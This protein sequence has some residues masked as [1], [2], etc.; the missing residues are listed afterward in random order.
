MLRKILYRAISIGELKDWKKSNTF[1]CGKNTLEGK[2]FF[3]S[4]EAVENFAYLANKRKFEPP[5]AYI[6]EI[7]IDKEC[8]EKIEYAIQELDRYHAITIY[9]TDLAQFNKCKKEIQQYD[10]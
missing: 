8:L 6:F 2:Q 4:M 10:L 1:R 7:T 5:Y 3:E 9:E